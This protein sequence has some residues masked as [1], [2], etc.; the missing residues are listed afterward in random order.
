MQIISTFATNRM[1]A[2]WRLIR[3]YTQ[4]KAKL[5]SYSGWCA[6]CL[7]ITWILKLHW[8]ATLFM[9]LYF[10][11]LVFSFCSGSF[12]LSFFCCCI[13]FHAFLAT[14]IQKQHPNMLISYQNITSIRL[15]F[16]YLAVKLTLHGIGH[17]PSSPLP[18]FLNEST[19]E[20]I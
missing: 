14:V 9:I 19:C 17:F 2:I 20:T 1:R 3:I 12:V 16:V 15:S 11:A 5:R 7:S 18:L 4:G 8:T 6:G 10:I 13:H